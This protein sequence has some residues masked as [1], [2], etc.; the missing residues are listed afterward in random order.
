[1]KFGFLKRRKFWIRSILIFILIPIVLFSI[2]IAILYWKQDHFV[3][4]LVTTLN[5]DFEG[6]FEIKGS[7][8][9]PFE[10]FPY[11]SI[12]LEELTLYENDSKKGKHI[13]D[14]HD[15]YVGFNIWD[16]ISGNLEIQSILLSDGSIN[17]VQYIDGRLNI[18]E[19]LAS[20]KEIEDPAEEFHLNLKSIELKDIDINK[21]NESNG[22]YIDLLS[23]K[24]N[25]IL[26]QQE[27]MFRCF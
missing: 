11:I 13:L 19:A 5:E 23:T 18:T 22:M 21:L 16:V 2:L 15:V 8:I 25:L 9:S 6:H 1:M 24:R 14:I 20:K 4:E 17:I 3:Q 7:H 12:D 10:N 26:K 27:M